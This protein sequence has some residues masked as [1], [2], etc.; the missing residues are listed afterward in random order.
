MEIGLID[1]KANSVVRVVT[2][3]SG[4]K[5]DQLERLETYPVY[6]L[7]HKIFLIFSR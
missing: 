5:N 1:C 3:Q 4:R 2:T 7:C 6:I